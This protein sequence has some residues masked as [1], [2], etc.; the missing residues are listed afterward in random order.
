MWRHW[1]VHIVPCVSLVCDKEDKDNNVTLYCYPKWSRSRWS[2][3]EGEERWGDL[4]ELSARSINTC[5]IYAAV[6][7]FK[8]AD[9]LY[10]FCRSMLCVGLWLSGEIKCPCLQFLYIK[11]FY[12][13]PLL[14]LRPSV[15]RINS[16]VSLLC[17]TY[18][19]VLAW[20]QV[21]LL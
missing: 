8:Y 14:S 5:I 12:C 2:V 3:R 16:A 6:T 4:L 1:I 13:T 19:L 9:M 17:H 15:S 21:S 20:Q 18:W 7:F 11:M 10:K